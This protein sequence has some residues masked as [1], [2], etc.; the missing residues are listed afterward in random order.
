[1]KKLRFIKIDILPIVNQETAELGN[2]PLIQFIC[3][4]ESETQLTGKASF[5][6]LK[7]SCKESIV[8]F[9]KGQF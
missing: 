9:V 7:L 4:Y 1:M 6:F 2:F 3:F 5:P 8:G